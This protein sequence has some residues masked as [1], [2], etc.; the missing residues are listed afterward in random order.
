MTLITTALVLGVGGAFASQLDA[1]K[2]F[3]LDAAGQPTGTALP[4]L[5]SCQA[6]N[7]NCAQQYNV[8]S[9]NNPISPVGQPTQGAIHP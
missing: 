4:G 1:T 2:W 3:Y 7:D 6:G 5:P 9:H 8:D